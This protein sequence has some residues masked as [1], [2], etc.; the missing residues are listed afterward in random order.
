MKIHF[1]E[2]GGVK[3]VYQV[4][5]G[6]I[7]KRFDRAPADIVCP[8]FLEL[9]WAYGCP[10]DC[11]WCYLKG[12]L[13]L[14]PTWT[15]PKAKP[16]EKVRRHL[17]AFFNATREGYPAEVLNSGEL[18]DSLMFEGTDKALTR[19]IL[20][21]FASQRKH[22]LLVVTKSDRVEGLLNYRGPTNTVIASFS[23]NT[24][25]AAARW[26]KGAPPPR[27]RIE[28]AGLLYDAGFRVRVRIDPMVPYDGWKQDY[29][30]L[31]DRIMRR[32]KPELITLG[33]LRGLYTTIRCARDKSWAAYLA[34]KTGWGLKIPFQIR[35][36]MYKASVMRLRDHGYKAVALCKETLDMWRTLNLK[37]TGCNC[38]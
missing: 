23:I 33:T 24:D 21:L 34:E 16:A 31:I 37:Y 32:F 15:R 18:A 38:K 22:S 17:E 11:S 7:I 26:E 8:H 19:N 27:A 35:A 30:K 4:G 28:A 25:Y 29:Q 3:L 10:Y 20:P 6:S 36:E 2:Y 13:R 1:K 12:T 14:L 5:D 9:K